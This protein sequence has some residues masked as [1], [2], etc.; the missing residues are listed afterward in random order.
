MRE[1][2][3]ASAGPL[4]TARPPQGYPVFAQAGISELAREMAAKQAEIVFTPLHS[5]PMGQ[6][7]YRDLKSRA[8]KHGRRPG[9]IKLMPGLNPIVGRT[10]AEAEEK[11]RYLLSLIHPDVGRALLSNAL[12]DVDLSS[13]GENEGLPPAIRGAALASGRS[14]ASNV[15]D[16]MDEEGLTL[17]QMYQRLCRARAG[18]G[19]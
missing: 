6:A 14:G 9:D 19:P 8:V 15:I 3:F 2:I 17:Q 10:P 1:S 7:F 12:G 16:T 18:S 5:I 4:N 13:V 11:Y